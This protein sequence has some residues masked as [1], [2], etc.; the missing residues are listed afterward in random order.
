MELYTENLWSQS[1]NHPQLNNGM[2]EQQQWIK[3]R[4]KE[5]KKKK[6]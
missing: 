6:D 1:D 3:I 2:I 4:E 5:E